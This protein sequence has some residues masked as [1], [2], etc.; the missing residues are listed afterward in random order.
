MIP[1]SA[2]SFTFEKDTG[3]SFLSKTIPLIFF[4]QKNFGPKYPLNVMVKLSKKKWQKVTTEI[5]KTPD[6]DKFLQKSEFAN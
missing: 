1:F 2:I 3:V 4:F 5:W 6:M